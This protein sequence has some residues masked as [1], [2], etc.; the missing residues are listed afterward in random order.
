V[1]CA[2]EEKVTAAGSTDVAVRAVAR[3]GWGL[4]PVATVPKGWFAW[5][6]TAARE[7]WL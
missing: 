2:S 5:A 1:S 6:A 4:A 3:D 7:L